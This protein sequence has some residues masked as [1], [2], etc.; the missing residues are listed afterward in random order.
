MPH[1][2]FRV[3]SHRRRRRDQRARRARRSFRWRSIPRCPLR[4]APREPRRAKRG[5]SRW[6]PSPVCAAAIGSS[7]S[8]QRYT[9]RSFLAVRWMSARRARLPRASFFRRKC[10]LVEAGLKRRYWRGD[11]GRECPREQGRSSRDCSAVGV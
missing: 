8:S 7:W 5:R 1:P 2:V 10:L 4:L 11:V 6:L 9:R 3:R